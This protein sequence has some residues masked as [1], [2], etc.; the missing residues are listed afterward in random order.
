MVWHLYVG[1]DYT[2]PLP[3]RYVI[4]TPS[5]DIFSKLDPLGSDADVLSHSLS[6]KN[7][8]VAY[9]SE[10]ALEA[11]EN[12]EGVNVELDQPRRLAAQNVPYGVPLIQ[13]D[14][15]SDAS[16]SNMTVCVIDSGFDLGHED[17]PYDNVTGSTDWRAGRWDEPGLSNSHGTH[18]AGTIAALNNQKGVVG[19]LPNGNVNLHII[20][21]F[22]KD[23]WAYSSDLSSA[24]GECVENDA[25]VINMSL[26]GDRATSFERRALQRAYDSGV[27][28]V[29]A[30]GNDGD[31]ENESLQTIAHYPASYDSVI[32]VGAVDK[33]K[34]LGALS[35][36]GRW[37]ELVGPGIDV[38]STYVRGD[39]YNTSLRI[40]GRSLN[41]R[42][43]AGSKRGEVVTSIVSCG[44][45]GSVC[46][47]VS[48]KICLMER[49]EFSF[50]HKVRNCEAGG[51][52]GAIVY[53]NAPEELTGATLGDNSE[54]V[55]IPAMT[56]SQA[57][58][59]YLV[60]RLGYE[61]EFFVSPSDYETIS[62]TSMASPHV[63]GAIALVWSHFKECSNTQIRR[64]F[65]AT[66]EDLGARGRDHSYG[67]GLVQ[68]K[69]AYNFLSNGCDGP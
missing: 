1:S 24:V 19:V 18:V 29:A 3:P 26:G 36:R 59:L 52:L 11:L 8:A 64:A 2:S 69:S 23:G 10:E 25:N 65:A 45:G 20:K 55:G 22:T 41:S 68:A 49:G 34:N 16:S 27:I 32:S 61:V 38:K 5:N 7:R 67:Y 62:G 57:D 44:L 37:L 17:L 39:G 66:A 35:Q 51:G 53:N 43:M 9:L 28:L 60:S 54:T 56:V 21:V 30:A 40:E 46:Q 42:E 63:A 4:S 31:H 58:G 50:E 33:Y 47:N 14:L 48:G 13:A 6:T 12:E 15:V